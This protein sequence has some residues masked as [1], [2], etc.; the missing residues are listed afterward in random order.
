MVA[1]HTVHL[2]ATARGEADGQV[3]EGV[4]QQAC[5]GRRVAATRD[6]MVYQELTNGSKVLSD[7]RRHDVE[8]AAQGQHGI[9]VLDMRIE[10]EGTVSADTVF[11]R[12][13]LHVD[14]HGNEVAQTGLMQHR[15]FRFPC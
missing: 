13:L 12:Q 11:R 15:A 8:R 10:R 1:E 6:L 14:D 7:F 3:V 9:H 5:H 2:L 4:E